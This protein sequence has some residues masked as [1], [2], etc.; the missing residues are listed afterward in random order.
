VRE[1][2]AL[3]WSI[4]IGSLTGGLMNRTPPLLSPVRGAKPQAQSKS[5]SSGQ[6]NRVDKA[7]YHVKASAHVVGS[8]AKT[9]MERSD[10]PG[11]GVGIVA[12][13]LSGRPSCN[14]RCKTPLVFRKQKSEISNSTSYFKN[15]DDHFRTAV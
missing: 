10:L 7:F 13:R 11:F 5:I 15:K 3:P 14:P 12:T 2:I 1:N 8:E 9:R 6:K 4:N